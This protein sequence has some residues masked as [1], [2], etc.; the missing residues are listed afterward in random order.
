M[1]YACGHGL[2][3]EWDFIRCLHLLRLDEDAILDDGGGVGRN[4]FM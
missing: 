2:M 1:V 3:A 4:G